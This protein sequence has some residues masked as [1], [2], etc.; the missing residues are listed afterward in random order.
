MASPSGRQ[1]ENPFISVDRLIQTSSLERL[2]LGHRKGSGSPKVRAPLAEPSWGAI[3][4][5]DIVRLGL[6]ELRWSIQRYSL[7]RSTRRPAPSARKVDLTAMLVP[8]P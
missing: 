8:C 2:A 1:A 6:E 4:K 7:R 5:L 3:I